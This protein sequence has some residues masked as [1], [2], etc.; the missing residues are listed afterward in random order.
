MVTSDNDILNVHNTKMVP[1]FVY[2]GSTFCN[3]ATA[4]IVG[5]LLSL[6]FLSSATAIV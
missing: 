3:L 2:A 4:L 6:L 1:K 5:Q